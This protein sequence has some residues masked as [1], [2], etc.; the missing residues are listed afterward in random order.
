VTAGQLELRELNVEKM[1]CS[2]DTG[3]DFTGES[4]TESVQVKMGPVLVVDD[5]KLLSDYHL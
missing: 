5:D 1:P 2:W 4:L 3:E